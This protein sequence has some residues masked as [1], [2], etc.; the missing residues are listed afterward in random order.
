MMTHPVMLCSPEV[1]FLHLKLVAKSLGPP[2][3]DA[4]GTVS[5]A[6]VPQDQY[7]SPT[8]CESPNSQI[9]LG[10]PAGEERE[11]QSKWL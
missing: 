7:F 5:K 6:K 3:E 11:R 8:L 1:P 2:S 4:Y 10:V 9:I